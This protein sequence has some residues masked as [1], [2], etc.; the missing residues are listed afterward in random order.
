MLFGRLTFKMRAVAS[1]LLLSIL[2]GLGACDEDN[3]ETSSGSNSEEGERTKNITLNCGRDFI[4]LGTVVYCRTDTAACSD[5][6]MADSAWECGGANVTDLVRERCDDETTC[7]VELPNS[8]GDP[9]P[10]IYNYTNVTYSCKAFP[11]NLTFVRN[12]TFRFIDLNGFTTSLR[13]T[14]NSK[15]KTFIWVPCLEIKGWFQEPDDDNLSVELDKT[16]CSTITV[17]SSANIIVHGIVESGGAITGGFLALPNDYLGKEY[18]IDVYTPEIGTSPQA[19]ITAINDNTN[20]TIDCVSSNCTIDGNV[21][22]NIILNTNDSVLLQTESPTTLTGTLVRADKPI[23]VVVGSIKVRIPMT[24]EEHGVIIEQLIPV[25][26]WGRVHFVP[27]FQSATNGWVIRVS[28]FYQNTNVT[29]SQCGNDTLQHEMLSRQKY[30]DIEVAENMNNYVCMIISDMPVQVMQY[31]ESSSRDQYGD[32][33]MIL[34]PPTQDFHGN[35]TLRVENGNDIL[36]YVD[37]I[38]TES[39]KDSLKLNGNAVSNLTGYCFNLTED[40]QEIVDYGHSPVQGYCYFYKKLTNGVYYVTQSDQSEKFLVRLYAQTFAVGGAMLADLS[41][42][43]PE[44]LN[45]T[46]GP[47]TATDTTLAATTEM[48]DAEKQR[49]LSARLQGGFQ[50]Y[51][52]AEAAMS[53]FTDY[54]GD[55][56]ELGSVDDLDFAFDY[57]TRVLKH[58]PLEHATG[59]NAQSFLNLSSGPMSVLYADKTNQLLAKA[60]EYGTGLKSTPEHA[61]KE[62]EVLMNDAAALIINGGTSSF[63]VTTKNAAVAVSSTRSA[64]SSAVAT[65]SSVCGGAL[66]LN[67]EGVHIPCEVIKE[68]DS[69]ASYLINL[70]HGAEAVSRSSCKYD[71]NETI[72]SSPLLGVGLISERSKQN[73]SSNITL[74]FLTTADKTEP[75]YNNTLCSYWDNDARNWST[76]GCYLGDINVTDNGTMVTCLCDH[77]TSF[78][79][80]LDVSGTD[81]PPQDEFAMGIISWV[82]CSLSIV[83]CFLTIFGY[84]FLRLH[85]DLILIHG[86]LALSV[87]LAEI[88]F[89]CLNLVKHPSIPCTVVGALLYYQLLVMFAWMAIEGIHLY[90]LTFVVWNAERRKFKYYMACGWGIP[91]VF[92][93]VLLS[94]YHDDLERGIATSCFLGLESGSNGNYSD[95]DGNLSLLF[96]MIPVA[97]VI[98]FNLFVMIRVVLQ[99]AKMADGPTLQSDVKSR[100]RHGAKAILILLPIMG[101]TWAFAFLA[102]ERASVAFQYIFVLLNS[103]QGVFIFLVHFVRNSEVRHALKRKR[104]RWL[105][106]QSRQGDYRVKNTKKTSSSA[107]DK[108][109]SSMAKTPEQTMTLMNMNTEPVFPVCIPDENDN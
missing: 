102:I 40:L 71:E 61:Q 39:G 65:E 84:T 17:F 41:F 89:L 8:L 23:S 70:P 48:S 33:S 56:E 100:V 47:T 105:V 68:L 95:P 50:N 3:C 7:M 107:V 53:A 67:L 42:Q 72:V 1:L 63:G 24:G 109:S 101:L 13:I 74:T 103:F 55:R 98:V 59:D 10:A 96:F 14:L 77:L 93:I 104:E 58:K 57:F 88:V 36:Q 69:R 19:A 12:Y 16:N 22:G 20:V 82:G 2:I 38:T 90:L 21:S 91:A 43:E 27:P 60:C 78:A 5:A 45:I 31:M 25:S 44:M 54:L 34:I 32:P 92:L 18:L 52:E 66:D 46:A 37:F 79:V 106:S 83:A 76:S 49:S 29:L 9:C 51:G 87:G 30:I 73:F 26:K 35:T 4:N 108:T 81:I 64:T 28:A 94:V 15:E 85:S 99:I 86:N 80:L 62:L 75:T 6:A 97:I 11:Q